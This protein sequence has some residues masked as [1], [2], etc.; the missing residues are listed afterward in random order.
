[1]AASWES[2]LRR[3]VEA[4]LLDR[5]RGRADPRVGERAAGAAGPPLAGLAGARARRAS[6]RRRHPALRRRALGRLSAPRSDSCSCW[7][8]CPR[9]IWPP[10]RWQIARPALSATLHACGT[11]GLGAGIFLSGQ[12]FNLQEHWPGGLLL[13]AIGAWVGLG[14][15]PAVAAGR[16]RRGPRARMARRRMDRRHRWV[17]RRRRAG[18]VPPSVCPRLSQRD[19]RRRFRHCV[20]PSSGS[21]VSR[22]CRRDSCS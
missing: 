8:W 16:P 10:P 19:A 4:G 18:D 6:A 21:V 17:S 15:A 14:A 12:I 5:R 7:P 3:W 2:S 22:F 20:A 9:C 11:I 13:W 1:M